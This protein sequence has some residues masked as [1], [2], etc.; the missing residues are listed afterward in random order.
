M[1]PAP[2][3]D[4]LAARLV[5]EDHGCL[6][7]TGFVAKDGYGKIV[8]RGARMNVHRVAWELA[9]GRLR[10]GQVVLACPRSR[11]CCNVEHLRLA[12]KREAARQALPQ[13]R[14]NLAKTHCPNGHRL[15]GK[16]LYRSRGQRR[17]RQCDRERG[18]ARY[19]ARKAALAAERPPP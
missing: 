19:H 16:N 7:Y 13:L 3:A 6:I 14:A 15:A 12:T 4:R 5:Y 11:A 1:T 9:H 8:D 17:C 10:R 2:L 18:R